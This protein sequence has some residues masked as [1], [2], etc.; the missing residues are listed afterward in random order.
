MSPFQVTIMEVIE[1]NDG[2]F[3]WYQ[4][5]R[6]LSNRAEGPDPGTVSTGLIQALGELEQA[7][8]LATSPGHAPGL[9]VYS[10]TPAG[11]QRLGQATTGTPLVL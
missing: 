6:T 5:D 1:A 10:L 7:G 2:R 4:L 9:P 3:S 8:F 11:R